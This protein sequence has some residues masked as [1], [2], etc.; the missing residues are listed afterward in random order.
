MSFRSKQEL[1]QQTAPRYQE[2]TEAHKGTI[3]NEFVAATG[4]ARKY[5]IR[6]LNHPGVPHV[7]I[8]RCRE[9]R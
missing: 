3:L 4:Y 2:A 9:P 8:E 7:E 5:A 6:V 1:V